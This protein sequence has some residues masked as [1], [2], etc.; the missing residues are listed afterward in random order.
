LSVTDEERI[1]QDTSILDTYRG[2]RFVITSKVDGTS[3]TF[4]KHENQFGVC[5]H[6][7]ELKETEKNIFWKLAHKYNLIEKFP[8]GYAIQGETAGENIQKNRIKLQG[9]DFF[10]FYV[11]DIKTG[12]YFKLDD[13]LHFVKEL[14]LRTVPIVNDNFIL[15][16]TVEEL[17]KMADMP[18]PMNPALPQEGLVFRLYD[19]TKKI[20]FKVISNAYL[21]KHGI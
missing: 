12:Q 17:L 8:D 19:S 20:S 15:N 4:F 6:H 10:A 11:I 1:Q 21:L 9:V 5:G 16:H 18:S 7:W 2:Q 3:S 14:G 13:M